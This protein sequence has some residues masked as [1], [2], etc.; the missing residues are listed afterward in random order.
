MPKLI[1]ANLYFIRCDEEM[2]VILLK[3]TVHYNINRI[4][5][6]MIDEN[7]NK[8]IHAQSCTRKCLKP[9]INFIEEGI[10]IAHFNNVIQQEIIDEICCRGFDHYDLYVQFVQ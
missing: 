9:A 8:W 3:R 2:Y 5:V 1:C 7:T 10:I 4:T 6:L